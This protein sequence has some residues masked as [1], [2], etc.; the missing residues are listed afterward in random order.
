MRGNWRTRDGK[1][2]WCSRSM[3]GMELGLIPDN[4]NDYV[5]LFNEKENKEQKQRK[6]ASIAN[7]E[8]ISACDYCTGNHGTDDVNKRFN[9]AEQIKKWGND[10]DF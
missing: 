9:A 2:H 3:R 5:D 7:A 1:V 4:P 10:Y 8:Y 6:F